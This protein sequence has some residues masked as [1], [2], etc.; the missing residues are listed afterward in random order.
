VA[1]VLDRPVTCK[2]GDVFTTL[3]AAKVHY[4]LVVTFPTI[5][6]HVKK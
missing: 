6:P 4:L 1:T 5:V 2:C 3:E